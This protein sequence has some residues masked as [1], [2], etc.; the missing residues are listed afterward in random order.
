MK[1]ILD[2]LKRQRANSTL[3][4]AR[5]PLICIASTITYFWNQRAANRGATL[6]RATHTCQ[7][8]FYP[9]PHLTPMVPMTGVFQDLDL[10]GKATEVR[11]SSQQIFLEHI[12][13]VTGW[14]WNMLVRQLVSG[15]GQLR[16]QVP[17]NISHTYLMQPTSIRVIHSICNNISLA[18]L[19][20]TESE[21]CLFSGKSQ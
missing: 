4:H 10:K 1:V 21:W 12:L 9:L 13:D 16:P 17:D 7:G 2:H 15:Q 8:A 20:L 5:S 14:L 3:I 6:F 11:S 18:S 19:R